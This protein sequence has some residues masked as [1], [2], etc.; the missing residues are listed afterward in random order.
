MWLFAGLAPTRRI[1][2][3]IGCW[4]G[5]RQRSGCFVYPSFVGLRHFGQVG[6]QWF[7]YFSF[8]AVSPWPVW[9]KLL[10]GKGSTEWPEIQTNLIA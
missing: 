7:C 2:F 9:A 1:R 4:H 6:C 8:H 5:N 10:I 3:A